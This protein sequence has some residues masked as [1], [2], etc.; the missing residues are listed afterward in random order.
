M[1]IPSQNVEKWVGNIIDECTASRPNRVVECSYWRN[2]FY[3]GSDQNDSPAVYNRCLSHIDRLASY[4]YSPADVRFVL[5]YDVTVGKAYL[6]RAQVASRYLTREFSRSD[7]DLQFGSANE[8]ALIKGLSLVKLNWNKDGIDPWIVHPESFGVLREDIT[9]LAKQEAFV[10]TVFLTPAQFYR[11]IYDHPDRDAIFEKVKKYSSSK[12]KSEKDDTYMHQIIIGAN[13]PVATSGSSQSIG[14]VS[15]T[16]SPSATLA[17]NVL[18]SLI[19]MDELWVLDD[20]REDYTTFQIVEP[21]ILIEGKYKRRNLCGVKGEQPFRKVC[22]N[23]VDGYFWGRSELASVYMLQNMLNKRID[24]FDRL[25]DLRANPPHS[26]IGFNGITDTKVDMLNSPGGYITESTPGAK[27]DT[28]APDMPQDI[29]TGIQEIIAFFDDVAGFEAVLK[30][31]GESGVRSG[32]HAESLIRTAGNRLRDRALLVERQ[33]GDL[34]DFAFKLLQNNNASVFV[35]KEKNLMQ[36]AMGKDDGVQ[37]FSLSQLPP[38]YRVHVDSHSS[39]PAF[40]EEAKRLAFD[41]AKIGAIDA[42]SVLNMVQPPQ[43]DL[44]I[45][46]A[47]AKEEAQ[48]KLVQEHPELA[49]PNGKSHK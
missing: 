21:N 48:A 14:S 42:V 19:R 15:A 47:E 12:R 36:W 39:S 31:Q 13:Q 35:S 24:D 9:S 29:F 23:E 41:L 4:L 28:L 17:P 7:S 38:D 5:E 44:L 46:K 1:K 30:G 22:P 6:E 32:G 40:S 49:F 33:L 3:N 20:E 11:T 10:H 43:A 34:G 16:G 26:F 18:T 8:I 2:Y 45:A 25:S 37:E 27:V